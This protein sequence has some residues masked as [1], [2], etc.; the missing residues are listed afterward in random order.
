MERE[1]ERGGRERERETR[2]GWE[3]DSEVFLNFVIRHKHCT[4]NKKWI[5][6]FPILRNFDY[7]LIELNTKKI[8]ET[9]THTKSRFSS[10]FTKI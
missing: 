5:V 9:S 10:K 2:R 6:I 4:D 8:L 1:R 7:S 3:S